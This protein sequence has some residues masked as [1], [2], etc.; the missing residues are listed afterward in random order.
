M[1]GARGQAGPLGRFD[2]RTLLVTATYY[3][4]QF[5]PLTPG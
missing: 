4:R 5:S 2:E 1:N 3:Q